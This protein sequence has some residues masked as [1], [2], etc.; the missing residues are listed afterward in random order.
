MLTRRENLLRALRGDRPQWA[1]CAMDLWGWTARRRARGALPAEVANARDGLDV[2]RFLENDLLVCD[3]RAGIAPRGEGLSRIREQMEHSGRPQTIMTFDTPYGALQEV[4]ELWP[5]ACAP[6][7]VAWMVADWPAQRKAY[8]A[9]LENE[10]FSWRPTAFARL[11]E[12]IGDDGVALAPVGVSPLRRFY[13]DLGP[14]Y[15]CVVAT[16]YPED[17]R[18]ACDTYWQRLWPA[19]EEAAAS[20]DVDVC[21]FPDELDASSYPLTFCRRYWTPYV[22]RAA[23]L[24]ASSGKR[25]FV[26]TRGS[27]LPLAGEVAAAGVHGLQGV[28]HAPA[29]DFRFKDMSEF[30]TGLTVVGGFSAYEQFNKT[31]EEVRAFYEG[32]FREARKHGAFV[33]GP[34][35]DIPPSV[36]WDRIRL[37]CRVCRELGGAPEST[38]GCA[39]R[40]AF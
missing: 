31:D 13:M 9:L 1:P 34:A 10:R 22:A 39:G 35:G 6:A 3:T 7:T 2:M 20:P 36:P 28:S 12:R 18:T 11:N 25:L 17:A 5:D 33:F 30:G 8:L 37:A 27:V 21:V 40:R 29:G 4:A 24:F 23:A 15:A 38:C 32:F 26:R 14:V 19:L 16:D